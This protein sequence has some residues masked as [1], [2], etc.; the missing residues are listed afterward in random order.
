MRGVRL[1]SSPAAAYAAAMRRAL[2]LA[3]ILA[4]GFWPALAQAVPAAAPNAEEAVE[5]QREQVREVVEGPSCR[6]AT[7]E[8]EI[9]VCGSRF[10]ESTAAPAS[11]YNPRRA[12]SAEGGEPWFVLRRGALSISCCSI[13]TSTGTGAGLSLRI[14]F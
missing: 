11:S 10:T 8:D 14:G 3:S 12:F 4:A 2:R 1:A 13:Q 6:T 7:E 9:V 5:R